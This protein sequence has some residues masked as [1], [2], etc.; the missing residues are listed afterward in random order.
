MF[1]VP[2]RGANFYAHASDTFTP[3]GRESL[4]TA[5]MLGIQ[6]PA[7]LLVAADEVIE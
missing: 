3:I 6:V 7:S 2:F 4:K 5:K 1:T